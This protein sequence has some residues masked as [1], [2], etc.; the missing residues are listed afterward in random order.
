MQPLLTLKQLKNPICKGID[1]TLYENEIFGLIGESGSGKSTLARLIMGL[2]KPTSGQ[3]VTDL[4]PKE[5]QVV[6]QDPSTSLNPMLSIEESLKEPFIIHRQEVGD[7]KNLLEQVCLPSSYLKRYP[8][9]LSGGEK[10]RVAI[11][12]SLA[13]NPKLLVLDEAVSSLDSINQ[14]EIVLLLRQ[15][16]KKFGMTIFFITHNVRL[17]KTFC[18]RV[19]VLYRGE[20]VETSLTADLGT[21][22][23][24][25]HLLSF[26]SI[27]YNLQQLNLENGHGR[28]RFIEECSRTV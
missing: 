16:Q 5:V 27:G 20:L 28:E 2:E 6:L 14:K 11:A 26:A 19:G 4:S 12:R 13:L 18:S 10:Q 25:R 17:V 21:H 3:I 15:L 9:E 1:L 8:R 24:T 22:P 7:L 23:Y